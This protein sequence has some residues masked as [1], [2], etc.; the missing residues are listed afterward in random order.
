MAS[1]HLPSTNRSLDGTVF[2]PRI[3][4][5]VQVG[6]DL[7]L[8]SPATPSHLCRP[9]DGGCDARR[10]RSPRATL[11][12]QGAADLVPELRC[13]AVAMHVDAVQG[14]GADDLVARERVRRRR[15]A[16]TTAAKGFPSKLKRVRLPTNRK[17][18]W[19]SRG[20]DGAGKG[21]LNCIERE[22]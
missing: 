2:L 8:L 9:A 22:R 14:R 7:R 4:A 21:D 19:R 6:T 13:V 10:R 16:R 3:Q 20:L 12:L 15:S 17:T 18:P 11:V 5:A 1:P